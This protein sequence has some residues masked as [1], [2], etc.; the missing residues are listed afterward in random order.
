M[1]KCD[2]LSLEYG[3]FCNN[4]LVLPINNDEI[5]L[6]DKSQ[7]NMIIRWKRDSKYGLICNGKICLSNIFQSIEIKNGNIIIGNKDKIG[8]YI[9]AKEYLSPI[10]FDTISCIRN[11]IVIA[12]NNMFQI[13][14]NETKQLTAFDDDYVYE[15]STDEHYMFKKH[16]LSRKTSVDDYICYRVINNT[17]EEVAV[18]DLNPY[19]I[20]ELK[21]Y[22]IRNEKFYIINGYLYYNVKND[23]FVGLEDMIEEDFGSVYEDDYDYERDTFYALGG[24][25]YDEWKNNGGNL[26]DM[27]DGMGF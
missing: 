20:D 18:E 1:I 26:D 27:M 10:Q 9:P 19:D 7:C 4:N 23:C 25:D 8:F 13:I 15:D 11:N 2:G 3:L 24:E 21:G 5:I 12:D 6:L 22:N 16:E 17:I 14:G